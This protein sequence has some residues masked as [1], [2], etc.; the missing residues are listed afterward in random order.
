M[1]F[2]FTEDQETFRD[3]VT[4]FVDQ[5]S[6]TPD[7]RASMSTEQ[8]Y[9]EDVWQILSSEL[10]LTGLIIPDEFGGSGFGAIELGIVMEQFGRS[11]ICAPYLSSCV[12]A[13]SAILI[14][15]DEENKSRWLPSLADGKIKAA[16]A[17]SEETGSWKEAD[18]NL[19][20]KKQDN[21]FN[22][23]G[24]K[25]FVIDAHTCD[26]LVVAGKSSSGISLFALKP[27][28]E[29]VRIK[30]EQSM[31]QTRKVCCIN[32]DDAEAELLGTEGKSG[33][34]EILNFTC[35]ALAHEMVGGAQK[36]LDSAVEYTKLRVQF[37]RTISS[38]QAIKHLLADLLLEVELAKSACY[39][40]AYSSA[41]NQNTSELASHAK[42][43]A[44]EA[45]VNAATQCIQLHGGVGFTWENDTH[46][47]F[48][49]AKS[50][51]V[52]LGAPHE[53]RERMLQAAGV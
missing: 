12:M 39:Y 46:L 50:S 28:Q 22:L 34:E 21:K 35:I 7:V 13:S 23:S 20:A 24:T 37:G 31:D 14:A 49:R 45:F 19:V 29:G 25:R 41:Q 17:I 51:E 15:A 47:W 52:F 44:S 36:M 33:I 48:K 9:D 27:K 53:H 38:F 32:F 26:L 30:L 42:A 43:Q 6:A 16:L 2:A 10:G 1:E 4:R 40:A 3:S 18:I 5:K 8:G 11:L